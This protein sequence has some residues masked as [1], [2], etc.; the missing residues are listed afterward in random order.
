MFHRYKR[1]SYL[2]W[3]WIFCALLVVIS[4]KKLDLKREIAVETN[5]V[6]LNQDN[7]VTANATLLDVGEGT[8]IDHG[9]CW[10]L[11]PEPN[12]ADNY[13]SLGAITET[14]E[15]VSTI[16]SLQSGTWYIRAFVSVNTDPGP[17]FVYG[18]ELTI[19]VV[20]FP[21]GTTLSDTRDGKTYSTV[22]IG[23]Q[24]WMASNLNYGTFINSNGPSD[25]QVDNSIIEKYCYS[26]SSE[27]C[28]D[29]GALY[30]WDEAMNYS[31]SQG[32]QGICPDGWHIPADGEWMDMETYLGMTQQTVDGVDWRGTDE[33][34]KIKLLGNSG[35]EARVGGYRKSNGT[36]A[37]SPEYGYFWSSTDNGTQGWARG[38]SDVETGIY[39]NTINKSYG[40]CIRCLKD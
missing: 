7:S 40:L 13:S 5:S 36:F 31:T 26:D 10:A 29:E 17:T 2:C 28:S 12:P 33:G 21:C 32:A 22:Q 27:T 1:N 8:I 34:T 37:G 16:P 14:G 15:Y 3:F 23:T 30:Q 11:T 35:F 38:V 19:E 18:K 9:H 20:G 24:C 25:N 4:C 6:Q 39:R